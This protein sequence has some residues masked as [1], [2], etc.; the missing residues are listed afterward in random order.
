MRLRRFRNDLSS[1]L[2]ICGL[3]ARPPTCALGSGFHRFLSR[4]VQFSSVAQSC[5]TL[6]SHES[7]HARPRC[8]S[9]TPGV[10]SHLCPSSWWC[11]PA[12]SSSVVHRALLF[13]PPVTPSIPVFSNE[14]TLCMR[15]PKYWSFSLSISPSNEHPGLVVVNIGASQVAQ[16]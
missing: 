5:L 4:R 8:P 13:L 9:P 3:S 10:Y 16:C 1:G 7:Q 11:H 2:R 15:W 14:S 12:I 6:R